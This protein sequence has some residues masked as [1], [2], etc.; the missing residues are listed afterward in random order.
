[1]ERVLNTN[2]LFLTLKTMAIHDLIE[3]I[4]KKSGR[5]QTSGKSLNRSVLKKMA[6]NSFLKC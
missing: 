2:A 4:F 1:M 3:V 5:G 6:I